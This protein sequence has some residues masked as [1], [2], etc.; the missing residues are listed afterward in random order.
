MSRLDR[1]MLESDAPGP[2]PGFVARVMAAIDRAENAPAP[3]AFPWWAIGASVVAGL[4]VAVLGAADL[5]GT[6]LVPA[7]DG[8][9]LLA[10]AVLAGSGLFSYLTVEWVAG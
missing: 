6:A 5:A 1:V 4:L 2:S 8:R 7:I 9:V 3:L 10:L